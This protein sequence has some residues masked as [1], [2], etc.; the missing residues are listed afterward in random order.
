[1]PPVDPSTMRIGDLPVFLAGDANG[2]R[3]LLHEAADEGHIAGR[4]A[5]APQPICFDR[6][7]PMGVVFCAP[8]VATVGL[9]FD[10]L[11]DRGRSSAKP[12]S[13]G[14]AGPG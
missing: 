14:R 5:V 8:N 4:N 1:M 12:I 10:Q 3:A 6:R 7:T 11:D 13:T 2:D 9:R